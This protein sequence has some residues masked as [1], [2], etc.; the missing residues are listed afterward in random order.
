[1]FLLVVSSVLLVLSFFL[2][3][4]RHEASVVLTAQ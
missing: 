1:L 4:K 2:K 3:D